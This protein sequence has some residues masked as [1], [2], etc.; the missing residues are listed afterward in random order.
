MKIKT[1]KE[2]LETAKELVEKAMIPFKVRKAQKEL[3]LKIITSETEVASL[4]TKLQEYL[5]NKEFLDYY[6][7]LD[8]I[9]EI[10]LA[11][12][13]VNKLEN[14]KYDLF[15]ADGIDDEK[16]LKDSSTKKSNKKSK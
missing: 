7:I 16:E 5:S 11:K 2:Y 12:R 6:K 15:V 1:Y 9:D 4:E 13:K 10:E 14:L 8:T 3:E